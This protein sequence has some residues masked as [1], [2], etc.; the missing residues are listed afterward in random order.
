MNTDTNSSESQTV[1][2]DFVLDTSIEQKPAESTE[3]S[4]EQK[5][6]QID[7]SVPVHEISKPKPQNTV[8]EFEVSSPEYDKNQLAISLP[9]DTNARTM[10]FAR[11]IPN[12]NIEGS[13]HGEEW[14]ETIK[15]SLGLN[16]FED[17]FLPTLEDPQ[18]DFR[19]T[20]EFNN[21]RVHSSEAKQPDARNTVYEGDVAVLRAMQHLGLG[22]SWNTALYNSG[23]WVTF[24]PPSEE[25]LVELYR[26][27][28]SDQI[29]LGRLSYGMIYANT[30][31]FIHERMCRFAVEHIYRINANSEHVNTDNILSHIKATDINS[32]LW[33]MACTMYPKG[34]TYRRACTADATKCQHVLTETLN[35]RRLQFVNN[36]GLSPR[37]RAHMLAHRIK[38]NL[39]KEDLSQYEADMIKTQGCRIEVNKGKSSEIIFNLKT[40]SITEYFESGH[41]W[42]DSMTLAVEKT[43]GSDSSYEERNR[44]IDLK[45]RATIMR[46]WAHWVE[47]IEFG[48]N[49]TVDRA[50]IERVINSVS[51]DKTIREAFMTGVRKYIENTSISVIGIPTYDCP[52]CGA[53]NEGP[54]S[55]PHKHSIIP[56]DVP[57]LFFVLL[58][59]KHQD[60]QTR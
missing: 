45:H 51:G 25:A 49:S 48:S 13:K 14:V 30:T 28:T 36:A 23:I 2:G 35:I 60:L 42:I 18:A 31:S 6:D 8:L 55:F 4:T 27:L 52:S 5:P 21:T 59:Q 43:L 9:S 34:F 40:P 41:Q 32:F 12:I 58:T 1:L 46:Q 17:T 47:S 10:E 56:L 57:Q 54:V 53:A 39:T 33:G 11:S 38:T 26:Q 15:E 16:S 44:L 3:L 50:S 29:T 24:K 19:Q 7:K 20:L 22:S 37:Q